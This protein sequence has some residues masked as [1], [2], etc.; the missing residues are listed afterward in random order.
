MS[1][2]PSPGG[3]GS[4]CQLRDMARRLGDT[5]KVFLLSVVCLTRSVLYTRRLLGQVSEGSELQLDL[6]C[7]FERHL[8]ATVTLKRKTSVARE[9]THEQISHRQRLHPR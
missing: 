3:G 6:E 4:A 8:L 5:V 7:I 9:K 1:P 2:I